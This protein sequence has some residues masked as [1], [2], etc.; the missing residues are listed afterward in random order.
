MANKRVLLEAKRVIQE[1]VERWDQ[2]VWASGEVNPN[3]IDYTECNTSFCLAG[4]IN[5]L[6]GWLPEYEDGEIPAQRADGSYV[7]GEDEHVT[8]KTAKMATGKFYRADDPE[9]V[10]PA[11]DVATQLADLTP[12]QSS[13]L[14]LSFTDDVDEM[15]RLID[16]VIRA[17]DDD[18]DGDEN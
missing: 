11:Q 2:D 12:W 1:N 15:S 16:E 7:L 5:R 4:W 6:N 18:D 13:V 14:F 3:A 17:G 9:D 10:W 8:W